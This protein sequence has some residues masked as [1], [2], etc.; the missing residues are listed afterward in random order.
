MQRVYKEINEMFQEREWLSVNV[1][2]RRVYVT[3]KVIRTQAT[4][5]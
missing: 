2:V 5:T 4:V 1:T 3:G